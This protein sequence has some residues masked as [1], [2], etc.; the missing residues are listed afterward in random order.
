MQH[1]SWLA[2]A[3]LIAATPLSAQDRTLLL[4]LYGGGADHL[5][6][7]Q[8]GGAAA[9]FSPGYSLG[10]SAGLQL[11]PTFAVHADFTF[12]KTRAW[13]ATPFAGADVNR[14]FYG[15]HLEARHALGGG[16]APFVFLGAGAVSIDQLGLDQFRPTTR[17]AMMYGGGMFY[18]FPRTRLEAFGE[19]KGL[20]YKWNMAGFNRTMVDV[21]YAVGVSYRLAF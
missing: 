16:W 19:L 18:A 12:T 5:A 15:G 1:V 3:L 11:N 21:T 9:S 8:G 2:A 10:A 4:S 14:F 17:A 7:L 13:G 6:D 20:S